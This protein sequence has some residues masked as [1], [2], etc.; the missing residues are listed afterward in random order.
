M[1]TR[2]LIAVLLSIFGVFA[3]LLVVYY[4]TNTP[5]KTDFPE[6][7]QI[8]KTDH[9]KWAANSKNLLVEYSDFQCPACRN[10]EEFI[11]KEIEA[12]NSGGFE[13]TKKTAFI[14]RHFPLYTIH[15]NAFES[16]YAAEAAGL[17]GKFYEMAD[18]LFSKQDQWTKSQNSKDEFVKLAASL[19]LDTKKFKKDMDSKEVKDKVEADLTSGEKANIN[20]T[21]T[22]FLNGKKIEP[23]SLEE[24]KKLLISL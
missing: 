14:F 9:V 4:L 5:K 11:K 18:L 10:F 7:N 12:S 6:V 17:Q 2:N 13:I 20:A 8:L 21:P 1:R 24:F 3:L 23:A 19:G 15:P 16:A 22:F